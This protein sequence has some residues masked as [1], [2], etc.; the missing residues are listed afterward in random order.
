MKPDIHHVNVF[1][2][3]D[4]QFFPFSFPP[5]AASVLSHMHSYMFMYHYKKNIT[6]FYNDFTHQ[7]TFIL[8][9]DIIFTAY[10]DSQTIIRCVQIT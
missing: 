3:Q 7:K 4:Q 9:K 8:T 10:F 2:I 6:L 5:Y 1:S